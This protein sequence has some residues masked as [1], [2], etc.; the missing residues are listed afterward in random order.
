MIGLAG[1]KSSIQRLIISFDHRVTDGL[2]IATFIN[3]IIDNLIESFP[4]AK[5]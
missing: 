2:E 4:Y 5:I 3:D 1:E